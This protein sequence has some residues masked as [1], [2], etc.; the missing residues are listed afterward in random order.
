MDT[1]IFKMMLNKAKYFIKEKLVILE[2]QTENARYYR[3]G[4]SVQT[5]GSK[6]FMVTVKNDGIFSCGCMNSTFNINKAKLCSHIT[7]IIV[8]EFNE[9]K[10]HE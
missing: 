2:S 4:N 8:F 9:L 5:D 1:E 3:V 6:G 7:A 10:W